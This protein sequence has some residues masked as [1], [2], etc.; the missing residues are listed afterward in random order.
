MILIIGLSR[1]ERGQFREELIN[2]LGN[3]LLEQ[4]VF[5]FQVTMNEPCLVE[6]A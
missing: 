6:E 1:L 2:K 4:D 5:G 3:L